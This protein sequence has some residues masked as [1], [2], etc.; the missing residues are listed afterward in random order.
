MYLFSK[1]T[2]ARSSCY[3]GVLMII[4]CVFVNYNHLNSNTK[5]AKLGK[6]SELTQVQSKSGAFGKVKANSK[7]EISL[8]LQ[9]QSQNLIEIHTVETSCPCVRPSIE[10]IN[11]EP[12]ETVTIKIQFDPAEEPEFRGRLAV[13]YVC[14]N[15]AKQVV[16]STTV[17]IEVI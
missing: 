6:R 5:P 15:E 7:K 1:R 17:D 4:L 12:G 3:T 10:R 8:V 16:F 2:I 13:E 14:R 9:N 11:V